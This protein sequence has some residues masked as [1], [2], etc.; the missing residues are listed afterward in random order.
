MVQIKKVLIVGSYGMAGH[1][2][3]A[4][5]KK[6]TNYDII[7]IA[8]SNWLHQPNYQ[9]DISNF[10]ALNLILENERPNFII[11]C[12]GV[13]NK[14]AEDNPDKAILLNSYFTH[15]LAAKGNNLGCRLIHISTDCVFSGKTGNYT[16]SSFKDGIGFYAQS[17]AIGEVTY[18]DNLTFRTSIIGPELKKDGIGLF[19]WFM[20]QKGNI[21]GYTNAYW[22]GIT[23]IEL[24]KAI[25][26]AIDQNIIGLHH[27]VND[28]KIS[29]FDLINIIK[30]VF[31]TKDIEI[32]PYDGYK[33]DK[34][35]NKGAN[36]GFEVAL[37]ETMI[38]EMKN[39]VLNHPH[40]YSYNIKNK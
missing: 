17:K 31:E 9:L 4:Y 3:Y 16:E 27:L 6:H 34:S 5:L 24:A 30:T 11:N 19:N 8:R 14:D 23:T 40:F 28:K 36:I 10:E 33:V 39:W 32:D 15:F 20:N 13:L 22:T 18:G 1:V 2:I 38:I 29:K 37:Y 35:L 12:V 21:K 7:D 25:H 26:Y